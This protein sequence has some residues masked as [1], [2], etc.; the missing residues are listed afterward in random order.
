[1]FDLIF[2]TKRPAFWKLIALVLGAA[3]LSGCATTATHPSLNAGNNLPELIPV[4]DFVANRDSNGSYRISPDGKKL[5]WVAVKG[6]SPAIFVRDLERGSTR[7]HSFG[8]FYGGF[9]WAQDSRRLIFPFSF[10]ASQGNENATYVTLDTEQ[11]DGQTQVVPIS[12]LAGV[13][14]QFIR[15]IL[16]DPDHVWITH[17]QRDKTVFDLYRV[18][19]NTK[20]QVL[21]E[22][23]PG[24]VMGWLFGS[25][26]ELAGRIVKQ[27]N[28]V[29]LEML[30]PET[31]YKTVYQWTDDDAVSVVSI[32]DQGA[33]IYMLS[34]KG[35]DRR[36]LIELSSASGAEK[37]IFEDPLVDVSYIYTHPLS[38]KPLIAFTDPD[39]PR[40]T[41]L[42][43]SLRNP[44]GESQNKLSQ[45]F[46]IHSSD[47]QFRRLIVSSHTDKGLEWY[48]YDTGR[49]LLDKLG[50]S[51][52][53]QFKD[54]LA[55]TQPIAFTSR[56][57]VPLHGYLTLPK[58]VLP[59]HLPMVLWVHGGPWWRD[60]WGYDENVQ[61][62][63]NRGYAVLQINFRGST[64]YG[65]HFQKLAIGEF[66][67]K[68]QDDLLDGVRWAIDKGIADPRRVAIA[69]ESYGGY[70][71]L[72]GLSF[73]PDTFACG[74]DIF[75]PTDLSRLVEDFPPD[76]KFDMD[77]WHRYVGDPG[78]S[79]DRL[80]MQSKSPLFKA[81]NIS[82]PLLVMQGGQDVRVKAEQ[83]IRLV[84]KMRQLHKPVD[85]WLE[86]KMGHGIVHWPQRMKKFRKSEDFLAKCMG[87]RSS[88]FDYYQLG[89]WL[90]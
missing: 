56:D 68:M 81:E 59:Q 86:P 18:N 34:N 73:T 2:H 74:I 79:E 48:L 50:A 70:A 7:F 33:S 72:V 44:F 52:S 8:Q 88:N 20:E 30:K 49:N 90:F 51:P 65:R 40:A 12:P 45:R 66:A 61:F 23:N 6:V 37:V 16:S 60:T 75:G 24:N 27:E 15:Q 83:S 10:S 19:I 76:W 55:D 47:G 35:R 13:K 58:G 41:M 39:Y 77:Q 3:M 25:Q 82:K 5:A 64:G 22:Q 4:R 26:G 84:D 78:R 53:L 57:R 87:G 89:A 38:G 54:S 62:F 43:Q 67:G 28:I 11:P 71:T 1:M 85:F 32:V 14:V 69:G 29:T 17:N 46:N 31:S 42:D 63:A 36:A 21:V 9:E 80:T